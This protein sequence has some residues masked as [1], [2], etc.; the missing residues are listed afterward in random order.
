MT[1]QALPH[2]ILYP[3]FGAGN[4]STIGFSTDT[5]IDAA[6]EYLAFISRA[7]E[8]MTVSHVA[9]R[10]NAVSGSPT[11][12]IRIE[13]VDPATGLPNGLWGTTNGGAGANTNIVTG[14]LTTS[15]AVHALTHAAVILKGDYYCVKIAYNSG[16]SIGVGYHVLTQTS[17][18]SFPYKVAN[19][20]TPTISTMLNR[21]YSM[22][23][24]SSATVFYKIAGML[25]LSLSSVTN[26]ISTSNYDAVGIRFKVPFKCRCT[27]LVHSMMTA[28]YGAMKYG[29]YNDGGSEVDGSETTGYDV[30]ITGGGANGNH[31]SL[32]FDSPATLSPDTWY[33]AALWP[34]TTTAF[35]GHVYGY[36]LSGLHAVGP[37]G[38]N[39]HYTRKALSG[40]WDD[41][42]VNDAWVMN[43]LIDQLDDGAGIGGG[44]SF[45]SIGE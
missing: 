13:T 33:R 39:W 1:L 38:T 22:A 6:G 45:A 25:P 21:S 7:T 23:L 10:L 18:S 16:T 31:L 43:L 30:E 37:G 5:T 15:M 26:S 24:G 4:N 12:D 28:S 20:G 11:A 2:A 36:S 40:A 14:T 17:L 41:S 27:G 19:T 35:V 34:L 29:I 42:F 3:G 9:L 32:F 8:D 44:A